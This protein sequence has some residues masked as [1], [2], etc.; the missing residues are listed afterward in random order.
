M[1]KTAI[2][3]PARLQA[4]RLPSKPLKLINNKE[5]ILHVY[6]VAKAA[7]ADQVVVATP[8]KEIFDLVERNGGRAAITKMEHETGT[9]RVFEVFQK[10]LKGEP[11]F[12]VNLQGD[13]PNLD[14]TAINFL[15]EQ[16][17]KNIC[18]V[19]TLASKLNLKRKKKIRILLKLLQ[20]KRSKK[21]IFPMP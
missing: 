2:I 8:D 4:K 6:N 14:P 10:D 15:I 16:M 20:G 19:G 1:S 5:M 13:M 9:D 11:E 7:G 3:I 12:I 17:K 21:R 18:D